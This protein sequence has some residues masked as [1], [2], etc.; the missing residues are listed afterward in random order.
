MKNQDEKDDKDR[1]SNLQTLQDEIKKLDTNKDAEKIQKKQ[2]K[3]EELKIKQA[4]LKKRQV[5]AKANV[6]IINGQQFK[7]VQYG[8]ETLYLIN[9]KEV[10]EEFYNNQKRQATV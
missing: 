9:G 10:S 7:Q 5:I 8:S 6:D 4:E 3:I 1:T 2:S